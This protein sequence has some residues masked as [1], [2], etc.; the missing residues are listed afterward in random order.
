MTDTKMLPEL[1]DL[2]K[3]VLPFVAARRKE[4]GGYGA[5]PMLPAT[6]EDTYYALRILSSLK[7]HGS[8][9]YTEDKAL[10]EYLSSLRGKEWAGARTTFHFLAACRMA[11]VAVDVEKTE[12]FIE[13]RLAKARDLD[14]RYY[15]TRIIREVVGLPVGSGME[16]KHGDYSELVWRDVTQ[17]WM[18]V[19]QWH[20]R[21]TGREGVLRNDL[22][23]WLQACQN[24]DGGFGFLPGTT[25]FIENCYTCL[26]A[27]ALL[28]AAPLN[29]SGCQLFLMSCWTGT[30]GFARANRAMAFLYSTWYGIAALLLLGLH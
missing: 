18:N 3:I 6:V 30:G 27:L 8:P 4:N 22:V 7:N 19:Y 17:L 13:K 20:G 10:R 2:A 14:E 1:T 12:L 28:D 15:C 25:S 29:P 16:Q 26:R 24:C 5:T 11:E 23:E 9:C 21:Q